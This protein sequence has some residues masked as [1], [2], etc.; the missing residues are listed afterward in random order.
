IAFRS[1]S[2]S[3][4]YAAA[5]CGLGIALLPRSVAER[6]ST[7]VRIRTETSPTPREVW[8]TIHADMRNNARVRA[9]TEFL[10]GVVAARVPNGT[11]S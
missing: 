7:L 3:S 6:D 4:I 9:V 10:A 1:D 2:V 11:A 8:Q 5:S